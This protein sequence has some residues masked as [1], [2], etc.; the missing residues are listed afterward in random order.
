MSAFR[1]FVLV[2]ALL[3]G[4]AACGP[5]VPEGDGGAAEGTVADIVHDAG[6]G[7]L[8]DGD[9]VLPPVPATYTAGVNKRMLVPYTGDEAP[10]VIEVD[11]HAKFL[12]LVLEDGMAMRY[13]IAVGRLGR[14]LRFDTTIRDKREWP[15]WTPTA[16]MLRTEPEVYGPFAGGV[17]GGLASPLGARALYLYRNGRDTRYR[18]HGTN[19]LRS[20]GNSGSAGCIRLFNH[21][22]IDLFERVGIPTEVV[23]RSEED[24][25]RMEPEHFGRGVELPPTIVDPETIYGA[26]EEAE[27]AGAEVIE[28]PGVIEEVN[29]PMNSDTL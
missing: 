13:P 5:R 23:M 27:G 21:D 3:L 22:I 28:T 18:I 24:S 4:L 25:M 11:I 7:L 14:A 19:D 12:Y 29:D 10:G 2:C 8:S 26:G 16:N 1:P 9:Y 17:P 6:Y 20:I 15:G